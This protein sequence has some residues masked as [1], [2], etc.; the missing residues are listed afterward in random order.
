MISRA[1]QDPRELAF[2]IALAA[3]E[4]HA[5]KQDRD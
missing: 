2:F 1:N 3:A 4:H 5:S